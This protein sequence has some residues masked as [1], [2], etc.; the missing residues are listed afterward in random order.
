MTIKTVVVICV[1][2]SLFSIVPVYQLQY[3]S[4]LEEPFGPTIISVKGG[5]QQIVV[6]LL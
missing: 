6:Q 4:G 3:S 2:T 5:L 1:F